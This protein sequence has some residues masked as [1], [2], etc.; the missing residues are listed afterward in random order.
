MKSLSARMILA[1]ARRRHKLSDWV[2]GIGESGECFSPPNI[3]SRRRRWRDVRKGGTARS[4]F[5]G[6]D[7]STALTAVV[8][9]DGDGTVDSEA[10]VDGTPE[11]VTAFVDG[12][13]VMIDRIGLE[14]CSLSEWIFE[15][16]A[17]CGYPVVCL[18]TRH[19]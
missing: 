11:A 3:A 17:E 14:A 10:L 2:V 12:A 13:G 9:A 15:S 16:L 8:I 7:I 18:E 19:L 4:F 5:A 1:V 6:L